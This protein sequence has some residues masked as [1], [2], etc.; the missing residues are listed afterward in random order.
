M[1]I[2]SQE[3]D[4]RVVGAKGERDQVAMTHAAIVAPG[5]RSASSER[6]PTARLCAVRLDSPSGRA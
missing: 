5:C 2:A 4:G 1:G 3:A 6:A